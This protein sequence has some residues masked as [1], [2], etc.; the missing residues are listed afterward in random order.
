M[1]PGKKQAGQAADPVGEALRESRGAW[2]HVGIFSTAV[3][4]LMLTGSIYMLQVY[5]RV[6]SSKSI[7]TLVGVSLIV[8]AAYAL[9]GFLDAMRL[10]ILVRIGAAFD[11]HLFPLVARATMR[12]PLR[13]GNL[14]EAMQPMRD[15]EAVRNFL[16]SL[17]P[18]ALIDMPFLPLFLFGC[19]LLHPMLGWLAVGG[20]AVIVLM[21]FWVEHRS[22]A[23][24]RTLSEN[25]AKQALLV[26]GGRRNAE[27]IAAMGME[28]IHLSRL[29]QSHQAYVD[30][31]IDLSDVTGGIGSVA[32]AFRFVLQSAILGVG[33]YLV[34]QG[35][36][37]GGAM[38]GSSILIGRA[39]APIELGIAHW[40]A[41]GAARTG[42]K[43]LRVSLPLLADIAPSVQLPT[44]KATLSAAG[45][46]AV[47]PGGSRVLVQGASFEMLA[48]QAVGIIG[49]SGAGKSTLARVL[50]GVWPAARGDIRL[51]G[52]LL[53]QW[54]RDERGRFTGYLPQD[55]ELFDGTIAENIAR[56]DPAPRSEAVLKAATEAGA[57]SIIL[58]MPDGYDTRIGEGG[59][60][61]S[62]GQRQRIALARALYGDPFLLIL[63]EPNS[64]LDSDGDEALAAAIR[65]VRQRGGIV[66]MVTHRPSSLA[67]VDL[68]AIMANGR[69]RAFGPRDE[70]LNN[71]M[72][73]PRS[74]FQPVQAER[75]T[76]IAV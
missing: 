49:P 51:D 38:I 58:A 40:K 32:K 55:V 41:L 36:M 70:V 42:L 28:T 68:V 3:N 24:A 9:Q 6:L 17:G 4:L 29:A 62:G 23:I 10:R 48:G 26:D 52:A 16:S 50:A 15:L 64:S 21:T 19:F 46:V 75:P 7:P 74:Q 47:A 8:L 63:D 35:E 61:L 57:H 54:S 30:R 18:T 27:V 2:L 20:A 60:A 5:D 71:V 31:N 66:V 67:A 44:P 22:T 1:N 39:L 43:R 53:D 14:N 76:R 34:I 13:G 72:Q 73:K 65:S 25:G 69:I 37:S 12:L 11:Q 56:F 33:A 45:V 59:A